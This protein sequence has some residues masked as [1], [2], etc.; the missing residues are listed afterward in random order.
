MADLKSSGKI[1]QIVG[2]VLDLK[3]TGRLPEINEAV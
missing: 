1:T 2:A 3:F